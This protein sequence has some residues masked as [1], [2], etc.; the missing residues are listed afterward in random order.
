MGPSLTS[1]GSPVPRR[2]PDPMIAL[3]DSSGAL[4]TG[5]DNWKDS[6]SR[7]EI[8]ST[9]F[10]PG[11]ER[12]SAT[13]WVVNP[14]A[15]TLIVRGKNESG[16]GSVE[17]YDRSADRA[18]ELANIS[19]RGFVETNDNVLIGGFIL[20][21]QPAGT[22]VLLRG[23]GPSLKPGIPNALDDP[24]IQVVD[25]NGTTLASNDNW[26]DSADRTEIE[27]TGIP[28]TKDA[29][30]AAILSLM[31]GQYTAIVRG[32]GNKTGIGLVEIYNV[33]PK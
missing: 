18:A 11:D 30:S 3:H 1:G 23:I 28:P 13:V 10:A 33:K 4:L 26:K 15:Y 27:G 6:P 25:G 21:N 9:G 19:S 14:G 29:E 12:E 7:S 24:T 17:I 31:P 22:R 32:A 2:L 5:N 20:S 8:Q 16:I